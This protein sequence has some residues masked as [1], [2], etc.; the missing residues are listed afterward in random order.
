MP[1]PRFTVFL[2]NAGIVMSFLESCH[3]YK[4]YERLTFVTPQALS[5]DLYL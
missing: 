5:G 3:V 1:Y 4:A 2:S